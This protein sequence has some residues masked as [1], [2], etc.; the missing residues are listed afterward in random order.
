MTDDDSNL[1]LSK[2]DLVK[3]GKPNIR[4][5][6]GQKSFSMNKEEDLLQPNR[7]RAQTPNPLPLENMDEV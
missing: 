6:S 2:Q 1:Q 3:K 5:L 7:F 4:L